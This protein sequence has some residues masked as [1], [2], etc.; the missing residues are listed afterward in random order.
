MRTI[1][2]G[3]AKSILLVALWVIVIWLG[4]LLAGWAIS[5]LIG[6][7]V[8]L[9]MVLARLVRAIRVRLASVGIK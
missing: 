7:G 8:G 4:L 5:V 2:S 3:V 1:I 6:I 9:S